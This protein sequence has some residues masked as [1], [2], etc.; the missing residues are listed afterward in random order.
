MRAFK[1]RRGKV[2]VTNDNPE[3][4]PWAGLV[5]WAA[6]QAM[7]GRPSTSHPVMVC[8][9]FYMPRPKSVKR[10]EP[11]TKP[12]VDKLVRNCLDA[13]TWVVWDD[14]SQVVGIRAHKHYADDGDG[15]RAVIS[16]NVL[17]VEQEKP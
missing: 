2:V 8:I 14:D 4:A 6:K 15:P 16:V 10:A 11:T 13:M 12:D 5:A 1:S 9:E 17:H 7:Q 3:T